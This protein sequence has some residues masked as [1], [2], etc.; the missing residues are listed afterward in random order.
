VRGKRRRL[1]IETPFLLFGDVRELD[2]VAEL[3]EFFAFLFAAEEN[4]SGVDL[5]FLR[6]RLQ[7]ECD[8]SSSSI[9]S[10]AWLAEQDFDVSVC[11]LFSPEAPCLPGFAHDLDGVVVVLIALAL[12]DGDPHGLLSGHGVVIL[13]VRLPVFGKTK[14]GDRPEKD[15]AISPNAARGRL[16]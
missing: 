6:F 16:F 11:G 12:L 1:R 14:R 15:G 9:V 8:S 10:S 3:R 7:L 5:P 2:H 4:G 13:S